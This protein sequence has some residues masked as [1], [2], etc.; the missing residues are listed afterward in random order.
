MKLP[1]ALRDIRHLAFDT[2]PLIYFIE[3]HP[4]YFDRM[5]CI[6]GS[7]DEGLM[8][9]VSATMALTEMLV[10]PVRTRRTQDLQKTCRAQVRHHAAPYQRSTRCVF[11]TDLTIGF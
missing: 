8:R 1:N 7:V 4:D 5:L 3:K 6:M 2:T 11:E 10:Q 9:G